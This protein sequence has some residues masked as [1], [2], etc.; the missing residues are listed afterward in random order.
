LGFNL[1]LTFSS[2]KFLGLLDLIFVIK[3]SIFRFEFQG[4]GFGVRVGVFKSEFLSLGL[5]LMFSGMN[6][7][8]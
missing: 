6:L 5:A 2:L 1:R 4:L 7:G 8:F 3:V